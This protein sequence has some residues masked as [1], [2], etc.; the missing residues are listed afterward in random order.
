[1]RKDLITLA[2]VAG[3]LYLLWKYFQSGVQTA[4][5]APATAVA[6][7]WVYLQSAWD[8][9]TLFPS[10]QVLGNALLPDGSLVPTSQMVLKGDASGNVFASYNGHFYQLAPSNVAG[11]FPATL[12]N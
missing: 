5:N 12:L 7:T 9:M 4:I 3:G 1:M 6:N 2:L 8:N 10:M 11:N